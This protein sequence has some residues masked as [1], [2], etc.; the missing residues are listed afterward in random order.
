MIF[1]DS[2]DIAGCTAYGCHIRTIHKPI[3]YTNKLLDICLV[4]LLLD[5]SDMTEVCQMKT[6][7]RDHSGTIASYEGDCSWIISSSQ[8]SIFQVVCGDGEYPVRLR[9]NFCQIQ[10]SDGCYAHC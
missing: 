7:D 8:E 10:L 9:P 5:Q 3:Y 1:P 4:A 2:E 6:E